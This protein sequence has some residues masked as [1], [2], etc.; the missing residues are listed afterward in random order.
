VTGATGTATGATTG[1]T[2][3][4][5][6][7][8][9]NSATAD[10]P[11]MTAGNDTVTGALGT[12]QDIDR[13]IDSSTTDS[14]V[15]NAT[16]NV[17]TAKP[18]V[19]NVETVNVTGEYT[20]TG[21]DFANSVGIKTA[22]FAAGIT[23]ATATITNVAASR[24][25]EVK[26]GSNIG[27]LVVNSDVGGT[28][29][30]VKVDAGSAA[31]V[32]IGA[33]GANTGNE[34]FDITLGAA[35]T[36]LTL[37]ANGTGAASSADTFTVKLAGN[38]AL[39]FNADAG[40]IE[41]LTLNST[42]AANT[43]TLTGQLVDKSVT[44]S[45]AVITGD[46]NL[47][48]KS[49]FANI[50][51]VKVE[52]TSTGVTTFTTDAVDT[53]G[54]VFDLSKAAFDVV[55]FANAFN[56]NGNSFTANDGST[57]KLSA[58]LAGT[59]G[60]K[61]QVQNA[62]G[63]LSSTAGGTLNVDVAVTQGNKLI[64]GDQVAT[65]KLSTA[66]ATTAVSLADVAADAKTT[67]ITL[68]GAKDLT[69]TKLTAAA[70]D[71]VFSAT[72]F[73]G[74][75]NLTTATGNKFV[76]V[77][78]EN[79]DTISFDNT[80]D[81][82]ADSVARGGAGND[83]LTAGANAAILFGD[84]GND[85]I[86]GAAGKDVLDG[87]AGNDSIKGGADAD[88]ISGGDGDDYIEGEAGVDV[89]TTGA[90]A[91]KVVLVA[92]NTDADWIKDFTAGTDKVLVSSTSASAA[93]VLLNLTGITAAAQ[94]V[95][96]SKTSLVDAYAEAVKNAGSGYTAAANDVITF[97][98]KT[99]TYAVVDVDGDSVLDSTDFIVKLTGVTGT[100]TAA[101]FLVS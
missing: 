14:D 71:L 54:T 51:G 89:I 61:F 49:S 11:A 101:D 21:F 63:T 6:F 2:A 99:D 55:N 72:G 28:G 82:K 23:G 53:A 77:G 60:I 31:T 30:A 20:A 26:A 68:S 29:T 52:D 37:E 41:T 94:T 58:D 46:K 85:T 92:S 84:A 25:A 90:G 36:S 45:K 62:A 9:T 100:L 48:I 57:V 73:T 40:Q 27:T 5:S 34:N 35:A 83:S 3:G 93:T 44:T 98:Y 97:A 66:S 91:D 17:A 12:I 16:L 7:S 76:V 38:T 4:Q 88:T 24:V 39:A 70:D 69:V 64:T 87:G 81:A 18:Q 67:A 15:F 32:T 43:L 19:I 95:V 79:N 80:T 56:A 10:A 13:I 1:T 65:L 75:L 50:T 33:T 86:T 42:G 22:N 96:D 59:N 47:T 74:K 8:L 78:G